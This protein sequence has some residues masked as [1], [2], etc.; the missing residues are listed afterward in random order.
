MEFKDIVSI[1]GKPGLYQIVGRRKNGLIVESIDGKNKRFPTTL[2]QKVSVLEDISIYTIDGEE[3]LSNVFREILTQSG[4]GL[5]VPTSGASKDEL[6]SFM[7]A[8]L[9]NYDEDRVYPS[10]I[11]KVAQWYNI[12]NEFGDIKTLTEEKKETKEEK[13]TKKPSTSASKKPGVKKANT[14]VKATNTKG[15]G[16]KK[17]TVMKA[18]G[19]GK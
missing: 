4:K 11:K 9:K 10:D 19:R 14:K 12:L 6:G 3:K 16:A 18:S 8:I 1:G 5:T 2:T 7:S 13:G 17:S 15:A